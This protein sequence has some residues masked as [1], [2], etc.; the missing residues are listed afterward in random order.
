MTFDDIET[1]K[2]KFHHYKNP[3]FLKDVDINILIFKKISF[4]K[5]IPHWLH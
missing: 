2:L 1:E 5:K 4:S 3:I